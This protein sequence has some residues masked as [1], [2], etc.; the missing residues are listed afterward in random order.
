MVHKLSRLFLVHV[1]SYNICRKHVRCKLYTVIQKSHDARKG[2]GKCCLSHTR[3][4]LNQNMPSRKNC[5]KSFGNTG[6]LPR[7]RAFDLCQNRGC[8]LIYFLHISP[9]GFFL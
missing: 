9:Y 6:I 5:S 8:I 7:N 3:H 2:D 1:K 4:I